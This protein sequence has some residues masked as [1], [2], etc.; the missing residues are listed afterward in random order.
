MVL[1]ALGHR[2]AALAV[3]ALTALTPVTQSVLGVLPADRS[4]FFRVGPNPLGAFWTTGL[5]APGAGELWRAS[6][7]DYGLALLPAIAI[8]AWTFSDRPRSWS[9]A[10]GRP[11]PK[12]P[13]SRLGVP[14]LA[15]AAHVGDARDPA[16][17]RHRG[18]PH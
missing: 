8:I 5:R 4:I 6:L 17:R 12:P 1:A 7:T 14:V 9:R 11:A 2:F 13:G 3:F 18:Q 15:R 10:A 16:R